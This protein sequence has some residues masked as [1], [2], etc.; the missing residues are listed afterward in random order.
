MMQAVKPL[1]FIQTNNIDYRLWVLSA[2]LLG[3]LDAQS[4]ND[5]L[6]L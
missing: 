1:L 5:F 4:L 2:R 6:A 3:M